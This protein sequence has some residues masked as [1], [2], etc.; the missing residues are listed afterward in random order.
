MAIY[1]AADRLGLP[2]GC[3]T[4]KNGI[5]SPRLP[6]VN[7]GRGYLPTPALGVSDNDPK[8]GV[9]RK[10]IAEIWPDFRQAIDYLINPNTP[11]YL[12]DSDPAKTI[13]R[14]GLSLKSIN[15]PEYTALML[16]PIISVDGVNNGRRMLQ[17]TPVEED[18]PWGKFVYHNWLPQP[19]DGFYLFTLRPNI[20][21]SV[22][23]V[24]I[25]LNN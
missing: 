6:L 14:T 15:R 10:K 7:F 13:I 2:S 17:T 3:L 24:P 11:F 5:I 21:V 22:Q 25:R 1:A 18:T 20:R 8:A 16:P 9:K 12:T 19:V 4:L 23:P